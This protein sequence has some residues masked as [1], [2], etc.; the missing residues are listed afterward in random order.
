MLYVEMETPRSKYAVEQVSRIQILKPVLL[1]CVAPQ[2]PGDVGCPVA[3]VPPIHHRCWE[4]KE[5]AMLQNKAAFLHRH[6]LCSWTV[7]VQ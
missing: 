1:W 4:L 5:P 2:S 6:S 7:G 3:C